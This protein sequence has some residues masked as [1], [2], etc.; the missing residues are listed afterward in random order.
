MLP[1][2]KTKNGTFVSPGSN[3]ISPFLTSRTLL[4]ERMRL[5]WAA[6]RTGKACVRASSALGTGREDISP[7]KA[8]LGVVSI[9]TR[10]QPF[11]CNPTLAALASGCQLLSECVLGDNGFG[12][13]HRNSHRDWPLL[14]K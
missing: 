10:P 3:R 7:P 4:P 2:S 12:E 14:A 11:R 9:R 1:E 8:Q 5:I 6:V 13:A